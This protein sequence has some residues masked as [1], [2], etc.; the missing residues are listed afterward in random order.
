MKVIAGLLI[1]SVFFIEWRKGSFKEGKACLRRISWSS[2]VKELALLA[3]TAAVTMFA[4]RRLLAWI[5]S[6]RSVVFDGVLQ[7]GSFL[8]KGQNAWAV[9]AALYFLGYLL[10]FGR[11]IIFGALGASFLTSVV[12]TLLKFLL[13]R[14]RPSAA[15]GPFSFFHGAG[16]LQD[17]R[18]FQSFPSGDAAVVAGAAYY[19][20]LTVKFRPLRWL[21]FLVPL[22]TALARVY[23]N[24]HW[25]SDVLFSLGLGFFI[26]HGVWVGTGQS[27]PGDGKL[28][29]IFKNPASL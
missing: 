5:Q 23:V 2:Y 1:F 8:G 7:V 12:T 4:D 19:L 11:K 9:L 3:V 20:F 6:Q 14:A 26:A 17:E 10:P 15:L 27:S 24:R 29:S 13:L 21:L 25:P 16:L 18:A 22:T 28:P